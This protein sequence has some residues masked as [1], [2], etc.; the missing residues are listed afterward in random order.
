MIARAQEILTVGAANGADALLL[1]CRRNAPLVVI[2]RTARTHDDT[3][4]EWRRSRGR[5]ADF[6]YRVEIR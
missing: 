4:I 3:A 5:A 6:H 2:E 1:A